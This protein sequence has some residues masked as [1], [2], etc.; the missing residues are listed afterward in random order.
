MFAFHTVRARLRAVAFLGAAGIFAVAVAGQF[1]LRLASSATEDLV[2]NN[3]AQRFQVDSD[4]M[5]DAMRGDVLE[6]LFAAQRGDSAAVK[7]SQ[8]ALRE[9]AARFM[10]SLNSADQLLVGT[11]IASFERILA[12][13]DDAKVFNGFCG[14]ESGWVPVSAIAPSLLI[15]DLEVER[16]AKGHERAPLLAPPPLS[17]AKATKGGAK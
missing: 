14:A 2:S 9:H 5:H 10:A 8:D 3:S 15:S 17:D 1:S 6:S 12:T 13:G 7:A 4:M 16:K 11:P